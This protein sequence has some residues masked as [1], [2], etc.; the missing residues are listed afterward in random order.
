[1]MNLTSLFFLMT[2]NGKC[3]AFSAILLKVYQIQIYTRQEVFRVLPG[4]CSSCTQ[5]FHA[6]SMRLPR[7]FSS[8]RNDAIRS[9]GK[10]S[11]VGIEIRCIPS[12]GDRSRLS[13]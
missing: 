2:S 1:M 7:C 10:M 6:R 12:T 3:A 13:R 4:S 9:P 5:R 11:T 8:S